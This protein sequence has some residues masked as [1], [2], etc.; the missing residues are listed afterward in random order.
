MTIFL[1]LTCSFFFFRF[2]RFFVCFFF[3]LVLYFSF[4]SFFSPKSLSFRLSDCLFVCL[5]VFLSYLFVCFFQSF[6]RSNCLS[7]YSLLFRCVL[8]LNVCLTS[9]FF[10]F[11][12]VYLCCLFFTTV[13]LIFILFLV[14]FFVLFCFCFFFFVF[15]FFFEIIIVENFSKTK[16]KLRNGLGVR[17]L[18]KT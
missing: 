6:I 3:P 7:I 2:I 8:F 4:F 14:L 1:F 18:G 15:L 9:S 16:R 17:R 5:P 10:C 12:C 13:V 11:L